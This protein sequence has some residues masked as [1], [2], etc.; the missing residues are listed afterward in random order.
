MINKF[1]LSWI[2]LFF[3]IKL[4]ML[5]QL[6]DEVKSFIGKELSLPLFKMT[7]RK[8][9][10]TKKISRWKW[11]T[12]TKFC[13]TFLNI[14]LFCKTFLKR[15]NTQLH[16]FFKSIIAQISP[17]LFFFYFYHFKFHSLLTSLLHGC[18]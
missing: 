13:L 7:K 1:T 3:S 5:F 12:M 10:N 17:F 16:I 2:K 18:S 14:I 8:D 11:K 9:K 15:S 4:S 6:F